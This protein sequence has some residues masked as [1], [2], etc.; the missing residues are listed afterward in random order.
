MLTVE[1]LPVGKHRRDDR[2]VVRLSS[3]DVRRV[4]CGCP[5]E[6]IAGPDFSRICDRSAVVLEEIVVVLGASPAGAVGLQF[7]ST[8]RAAAESA[9]GPRIRVGVI[10]R[11]PVDILGL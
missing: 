6:K 11:P 4:V 5:I 1:N 8:G 2:R 10:P 7:R 3:V 9:V